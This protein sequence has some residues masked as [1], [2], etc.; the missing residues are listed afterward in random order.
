MGTRRAAPDP[1]ARLTWEQVFAFRLTRQYLEPRTSKGAVEIVRRL[2]GVQAQVASAAAFGVATRRHNAAASVGRAIAGR[3]LVKTWAMRG[4]LHLL[5]ADHAPTYLATMSRLTPWRSKAWERYHGVT[6]SEVERVRE[7][8]G[9]VLGAEP[10]TKQELAAAL[11]SRLR[12]RAARERLASGWGEML[13]PAAWA[14]VLLHGPPRGTSV[15]F[16]RADAWVEGW[17]TPDPDEAGATVLRSYLTAFGPA[18]EQDVADWWARQPANKVRPWFERLGDEVVPVDVDGRASWALGRDVP[19]LER[20]TPSDAVRLLGNFDQY[21]LGPGR[22]SAAFVPAEH[23]ARV[24]RAA[25]WISKVVL[26]G[27]RV[28]GVWDVDDDGSA[29][30]DLWDEV[31]AGALDIELARAAG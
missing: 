8:L 24:S 7:A 10:L 23:R 17:T 6:G 30:V 28:A 26:H 27:G 14:G 16:V 2:C 15:T 31:P 3:S 4:T 29:V 25:G 19:A 5:P 9:E 12:S 21:V 18:A 1:V 20:A 11:G 22:G 13:K